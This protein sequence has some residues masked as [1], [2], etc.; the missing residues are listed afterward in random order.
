VISD[1]GTFISVSLQNYKIMG[2]T[3]QES[4]MILDSLIILIASSFMLLAIQKRILVFILI[5][6]SFI[7]SSSDLGSLSL[8]NEC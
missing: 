6:Y 5:R 4:P 3:I 1:N 8:E 7:L 2:E